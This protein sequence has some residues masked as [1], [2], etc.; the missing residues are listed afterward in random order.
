MIKIGDFSNLAHISIKTLHHYD[1]LGLL[2]PAS[3]DRFSG[4]RYYS[5]Q[6]LATLNRILALKD[7]GLSLEQI[8][9]LLRD[10]ISPAEMRGMLRLK[11]VEL[12]QKV[13]EEQAQLARVEQRLRQLE[14][15]TSPN[16]EIAV[17]QV[18]AQTI[19]TAQIVA[20][21]E[22]M[23]PAA[24]QSLQRLLQNALEQA[25]LK[26]AGP[27]FALMDSLPYI[28]TE[29][30]I[31]LGIPVQLRKGQRGGD[32][33]D[34]PVRLQELAA[35]SSMV[36]IV[37]TDESS[38]L[39]QTYTSLYA[40]TQSNGYRIAGAFREIYLSETP[41][42]QAALI[43]LQCPVER[44]SV[45]LSIQPKKENLM[46]PTTITKP[47]IITL[48]AFK[49]VGYSYIGSNQNA[50]ISAMWQRFLPHIDEP[51]RSDPHTAY[52]LC[53][54]DN[55]NV[56]EGEFEYVA[57]VEV[58]N[59]ENIPAGM[60][61]REVPAHKYAV[62]THHGKLDT[63]HDTFDYIFNTGLAQA[64]LQAHPSGLEMEVYKDYFVAGSDD[65]KM[66]IYVALQ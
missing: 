41:S 11:Q 38:P 22:E 5:I 59:G 2:K 37:H 62:F 36:S 6:Q 34:T 13:L 14:Q 48:P 43:E 8:A 9:Q 12:A 20:A 39:P 64:G 29:R 24:R 60:I 65:S 18:P 4:Y 54:M 47:S 42:A 25:Q 58:P 52:G 26:A 33:D 28:E 63:L 19:L 35:V 32:W 56:K 31:R 50:E 1:E 15:A 10:D 17:K 23:I 55:P 30:E 21:R 44:A 61:Y 45:P 53:I 57:C 3:I 46:E 66:Y 49:T 27:W 51:Q 40:W 16:A 7:L